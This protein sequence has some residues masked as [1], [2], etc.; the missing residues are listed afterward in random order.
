MS[1]ICCGDILLHGANECTDIVRCQDMNPVV[2]M[3]AG[4][5]TDLLCGPTRHCFL[6]TKGCSPQFHDYSAAFEQL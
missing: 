3:V 2:V 6:A 4:N 1:F 5:Q